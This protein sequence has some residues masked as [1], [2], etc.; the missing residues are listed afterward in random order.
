MKSPKKVTASA[1]ISNNQIVVTKGSQI[2]PTERRTCR[3][4]VQNMRKEL[5]ENGKVVDNIFTADTPFSS[6]S[7]AAAAILGGESNG[8]TLWRNEDGKTLKELGMK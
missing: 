1:F 3:P 4:W 2:S 8:Q 7:A 6:P 5:L